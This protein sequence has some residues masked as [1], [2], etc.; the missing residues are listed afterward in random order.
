[1]SVQT[2]IED[3]TSPAEIH[4]ELCGTQVELFLIFVMD[5]MSMLGQYTLVF[6]EQLALLVLLV[7]ACV[8]CV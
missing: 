5:T 4:E 2:F 3:M 8:H 1:M 7:S 6:E